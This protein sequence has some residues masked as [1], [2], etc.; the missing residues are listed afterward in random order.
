GRVALLTGCV[1]E[2]L[3]S[4]TNR[5][6][7]RTLTVNGY[8]NVAADGQRCCG[9]LHAHAGD[10][11]GARALARANIEAFERANV[12]F[13]CANAAGCGAMMKDYGQLL[14]DDAQWAD[15]AQRLSTKVRDVSELLSSVGPRKGAP[16]PAQVSYDAPCHLVHAQRVSNPP[17]DVLRAV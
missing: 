1:M 10:A 16:F 9:A 13:V 4:D 12:D 11:G 2:G 6:T 8:A 15:R 14:A 17:L 5:A 3:F 7:E